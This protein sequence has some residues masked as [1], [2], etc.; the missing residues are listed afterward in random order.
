MKNVVCP[1]SAERVPE[2]LP[3]IT[4]LL[5]ICLL[6]TYL[7]TGY[8]LVLMFLFIDFIIRGAGYSR[9][10]IL[11]VAANGVSKILNI[12]SELIDKAPKLFAARLGAVMI[13]VAVVFEFATIPGASIII[14]IML[15]VFASLECVFNFCLGCYV[16]NFLVLPVF[17]R[18]G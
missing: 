5:V 11:H 15:G 12:R 9:F 6:G 14:A 1:I 3:R 4:A 17:S 2:H 13:G 18:N 7:F 8:V 10:S 16:Y